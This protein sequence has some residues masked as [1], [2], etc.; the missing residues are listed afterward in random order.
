MKTSH[1]SIILFV[2]FSGFFVLFIYGLDLLS[3][4]EQKNQD[5]RKAGFYDAD[6]NMRK[7]VK[8]DAWFNNMNGWVYFEGSDQ[9][10][11]LDEVLSEYLK[12]TLNNARE[13][14]QD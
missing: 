11:R 13:N 3:K 6:G 1:A 14:G 10:V 12:H 8:V 7:V 2:V 9:R 5:A 4:A